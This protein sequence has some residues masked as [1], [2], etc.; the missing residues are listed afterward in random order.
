[1]IANIAAEEYSHIELVAY[2]INLLL[3][4]TTKRG[5]LSL[6]SGQKRKESG[7][8]ATGRI[9]EHLLGVCWKLYVQLQKVQ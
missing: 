9:A 3:T 2:T 8:R 4:D 6:M 5:T 1:L 7:A